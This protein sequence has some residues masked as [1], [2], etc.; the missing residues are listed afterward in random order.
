[1]SGFIGE[2]VYS[3]S[4]V[5]PSRVCRCGVTDLCA[6]SYV[7]RLK[8][9]LFRPQCPQPGSWRFLG[10]W[11]AIPTEWAPAVQCAVGAILLQRHFA[12]S[13]YSRVFDC[14]CTCGCAAD[15]QLYFLHNFIPFVGF[16]FCDNFVGHLADASSLSILF[17]KIRTLCHLC[18][19]CVMQCCAMTEIMILAGA[20]LRKMRQEAQFTFTPQRKL[21][22]DDLY[23]G[24]GKGHE[25]DTSTQQALGKV[26]FQR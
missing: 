1:M 7:L 23:H 22:D 19:I 21:G 8:I 9:C 16:G 2:L 4:W 18:H 3:K 14:D 5:T 6:S 13:N 24:C 20:T 17:Q 15:A 26:W 25:C 12:Y 11:G 10:N